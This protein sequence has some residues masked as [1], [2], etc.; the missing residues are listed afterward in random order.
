M[1]PLL[2]LI[3]VPTARDS[4]TIDGIPRQFLVGLRMRKWS[5]RGIAFP[6]G[7]D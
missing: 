5:G 3:C 6:V 4:R 1:K 7:E 2:A